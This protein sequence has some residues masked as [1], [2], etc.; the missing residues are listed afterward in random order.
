MCREGGRLITALILVCQWLQVGE[1]R[2]LLAF[3]AFTRDGAV[4]NLR[5]SM[6]PHE[7][8]NRFRQKVRDRLVEVDG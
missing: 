3:L 1:G 5:P 8:G 7:V 4:D 2:S 6:F